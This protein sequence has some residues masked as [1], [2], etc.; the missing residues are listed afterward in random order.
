MTFEFVLGRMLNEIPDDIDKR[1]GSVIYDALAPAALELS[2]FYAA[3]GN[4]VDETFADSA[5]RDMLIRRA[6][7]R[8][9]K[10]YEATFAVV[11]GTFN[12]AV[13]AGTRFSL[14][15]L[16]YRV[17]NSAANRLICENIGTVGNVS[18]GE[19]IPVDYVQGLT[20][21]RIVELLIPGE[22]DETTE[23]LR[24][25]YF[26]SLDTQ[27]YGGNAADYRRIALA[28]QGV[29]G[30]KVY[31]AFFGGGTVRLVIQDY[32]FSV[33]SA[34]LVGEVKS[35]I[36]PAGQS[37]LGVGA[38]PIGHR[39]TVEAVRGV[40]VNT[41]ARF[42]M[43]AGWSF[44]D[45]LSDLEEIVQGYLTEI[46]AAWDKADGVIVRA[47]QIESRL[48]GH[49]GILD[50]ENFSLNNGVAGRSITLSSDSIPVRGVIR[51]V[52]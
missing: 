14:G 49:G 4:V 44:N 39:V 22:D 8:G 38:A 11:R 30:V 5:G 20:N 41:S 3:L 9:I 31:P 15:E 6:A 13:A 32:R 45:V 47:S 40:V 1:V 50:I 26:D 10:P 34:V 16:R 28:I 29:G 33:P 35:I 23:H 36:D 18:A 24:K 52:S 48:L 2:K 12:I 27:S 37:G 46:A 51:N 17:E 21:A 7:E 42:I 25:R 43:T 19:L